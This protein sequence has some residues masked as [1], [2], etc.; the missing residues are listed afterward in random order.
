MLKHRFI[1]PSVVHFESPDRDTICGWR[2]AAGRIP[3]GTPQPFVRSIIAAVEKLGSRLNSN[4]IPKLVIGMNAILDSLSLHEVFLSENINWN[5]VLF[6]HYCETLNDKSTQQR[7]RLQEWAASEKIYKEL[8]RAGAIPSDTS[9]PSGTVRGGCSE[10]ALAPIGFER[11][12]LETP[13]TL[14]DLLPKKSLIAEGLELDDEEFI[15]KLKNRLESGTLTIFELLN[16]YWDS[17]C[18]CHQTG[19]D[20]MQRVPVEELTQRISSGDFFY[21]DMHLAHPDSPDGISWFLRATHYYAFVTYKLDLLNFNSISGLPFFTKLFEIPG[22]T[23]R[24]FEK[25][26][27]VCGVDAPPFKARNKQP[28]EMISRLLGLLSKR[29][30]GVACCILTIENPS[31]TADSITNAD[32]YSQNGKFYVKARTLHRRLVFSVSKPR[33][34][35]RKISLLSSVS[36]KVITDIIR[37]TSEIRA[38]QKHYNKANWRKLFLLS[39]RK[40]LGSISRLSTA[41]GAGSGITLYN[42]FKDK[43]KSE[44]IDKGSFNLS[45]LRTTQA[46][47]CF[48]THGSLKRVADLLNNTIQ[49]VKKD[50]IPI[51]LI[52]YWGNRILRSLQ[53]KFIVVAT[54]GSP[55][56]LE[57]SDFLDA[58]SLRKFI[59]KTLRELKHGDAFSE[60]IRDRLG[61]YSDNPKMTEPFINSELIIPM[62]SQALTVLYAYSDVVSENKSESSGVAYQDRETISDPQIRS[63]ANLIRQCNYLADSELSEAEYA[64]LS[65]IS[66]DSLMQF[67]RMHLLAT[68]NAKEL[69]LIFRKRL[70]KIEQREGC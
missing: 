42:L 16:D 12:I 55:W 39:S 4:S 8:V 14:S 63:I 48:L 23:D 19:Q 58:A 54:E 28:T 33:A 64:I 21:K 43:L 36:A 20:L 15:E 6:I 49:T 2:Y 56:Q 26:V 32:L 18:R 52:I 3:Q 46:I 53:Q 30:C 34:R 17:M 41:I 5:E 68:E 35:K 24:I 62:N 69:S 60:M 61:K 51:W 65:K 70:P 25:L 67:Q 31:F 47:I 10:D 45:S 29:D 22:I 7:T 66:G 40:K 1:S 38:R 59:D 57:A 50:Y 44:K 11:K 13:M 9:I 37:S 27:D